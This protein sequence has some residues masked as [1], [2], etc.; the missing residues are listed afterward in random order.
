MKPTAVSD[1]SFD[2]VVLRASEPVLVDF[3]AEWCGPCKMIAP[4]LD[5]LATEMAGRVDRRQGQHRR[6]PADPA[7][8][9]RARHPDDDAVQGRPGGGDQDRRLAEEQALRVGR[10]GAVSLSL[11]PRTRSRRGRRR[12][13]AASRRSAPAPA[14][15]RADDVAQRRC[16][17][18]AGRCA[19]IPTERA[20]VGDRLSAGSGF[21]S[22]GIVDRME[23]AR[24]GR[25]RGEEA[26]G[27]LGIEHADDQIERTVAASPS[28]PRPSTSPAAGLWPPSS[29]NSHPA[30]SSSTSG[31]RVRRCSR[32]GQ[33]ICA[34]PVGE[35]ARRQTQI[36]RAA[37][38]RR[39]PCRHWRS[40]APRAATGSGRSSC[41]HA[42]AHSASRRRPRRT[43]IP[44][45]AAIERRA[46]RRGAR[47]DDR[48]G[49]LRLRRRSPP[50]R[51]GFR[52]PAFSPA[53]AASV[54]PRNA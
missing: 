33:S 49:L 21:S 6:E 17:R 42:A 15:V 4:F 24:V 39:A 11:P 8:I 50:A 32:A 48:R 16:D 27:I 13:G 53:I 23:R 19:A 44:C 2:A 45:R 5:E 30:G 22:P 3:W 38:G 47:R 29:H 54:S 9:R 28:Q 46:D 43:A 40:G 14:P 26:G 36:P 12:P 18:L 1:S 25:E 20:A 51:P 52:M 7:Q 34:Q 35:R 10:I 41:H 37:P 31:P